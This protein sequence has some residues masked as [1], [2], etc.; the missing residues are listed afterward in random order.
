MLARVLR[1]SAVVS[2][3]ACLL[4]GCASANAPAARVSDRVNLLCSN[5][6]PA[7]KAIRADQRRVLAGFSKGTVSRAKAIDHLHADFD[8][9][10]SLTAQLSRDIARLATNPDDRTRLAPLV[11]AYAGLGKVARAAA[12]AIAAKDVKRFRANQAHAIRQSRALSRAARRALGSSA[13]GLQA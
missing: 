4:A 13:C 11:R 3:V 9:L 6:A 7:L 12:D 1:V 5:A 8:E 10:G 2:L